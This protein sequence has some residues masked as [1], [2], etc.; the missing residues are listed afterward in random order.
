MLIETNELRTK[1]KKHAAQWSVQ[2]LVSHQ[3]LAAPFVVEHGRLRSSWML[4]GQ[5]SVLFAAPFLPRLLHD[6][7]CPLLRI[8]PNF[9]LELSC[10]LC[11]VVNNSGS[12]FGYAMKWKRD[13]N[14]ICDFGHDSVVESTER[15]GVRVLVLCNVLVELCDSVVSPDGGSIV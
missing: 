6:V 8:D 11:L 10:I 14:F 1:L 2:S 3:V 4:R 9:V 7:V 13:R 15:V 5:A 12:V